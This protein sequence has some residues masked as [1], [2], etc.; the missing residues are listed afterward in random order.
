[1]TAD[2]IA[3][4]AIGPARRVGA[5]DRFGRTIEAVIHLAPRVARFMVVA[6]Q[7]DPPSRRHA[8]APR[9][10]FHHV[11]GRPDPPSLIPYPPS[12]GEFLLSP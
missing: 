11:G 9:T 1:V 2:V 10:G 6:G 3:S 5:V 4:A 7:N 12:P 8:A